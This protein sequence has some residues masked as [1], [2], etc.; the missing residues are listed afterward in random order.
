MISKI[1]KGYE[2]NYRDSKK[3]IIQESEF[4][5]RYHMND[6]INKIENFIILETVINDKEHLT[7]DKVIDYMKNIRSYKKDKIEY[8]DFYNKITYLQYTKKDK[9]YIIPIKPNNIIENI[10][11]QK[12]VVL[13]RVDLK[14]TL[15]LLKKLDD[16]ELD[17]MLKDYLK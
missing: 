6:I 9:E 1:K 12:V 4:Q 10:K 16:M 2:I 11:L 8:I 3:S 7:R 17:L 15:Q 5:I 14:L 13:P